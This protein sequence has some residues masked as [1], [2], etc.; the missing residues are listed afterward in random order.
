MRAAAA[1]TLLFLAGCAS[2]NSDVPSSRRIDRDIAATHRG[3]AQDV[4]DARPLQPGFE[5]PTRGSDSL[6]PSFTT[7]APSFAI[8]R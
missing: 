5:P 3:D 4:R 2:D 1:L 8:G 7:G 6:T